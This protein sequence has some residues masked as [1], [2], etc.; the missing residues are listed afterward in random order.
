MFSNKSFQEPQFALQ[1]GVL[2]ASRNLWLCVRTSNSPQLSRLEHYVTVCQ[3][4]VGGK[5]T[6]LGKRNNDTGM[7][8]LGSSPFIMVVGVG[9]ILTPWQESTVVISIFIEAKKQNSEANVLEDIPLDNLHGVH[10]VVCY[11]TVKHTCFTMWVAFMVTHI[12]ICCYGFTVLPVD[13]I[14]FESTHVTKR[15]SRGS[16]DKKIETHGMP[17]GQTSILIIWE[18]KNK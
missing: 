14:P 15:Q 5:F 7:A 13:S 8:R 6:I 9:N 3:L 4:D 1:K 12:Y 11:L 2:Y 17:C 10:V 16:G 18:N